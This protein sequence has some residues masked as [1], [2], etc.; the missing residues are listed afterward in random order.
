MTGK[1]YRLLLCHLLLFPIVRGRAQTFQ[2]D[3]STFAN[4]MNSIFQH[5]QR[6]RIPNGILLD[7]AQEFTNL[8]AY[9]GMNLNDSTKTTFTTVS[10]IY[11]TLA[12]GTIT[13][14][15]GSVI[16]PIY[17]DSLAQ[18]QRTAGQITLQ[19]LFYQY[20]SIVPN[21]VTNNLIT[22]TSNQLYDKYVNSV[23]QNPYQTQKVYAMS[24]SVNAYNTRG[25]YALKAK[26]PANLWLTNSGSLVSGM[27]VDFADGLGFRTLTANQIYNLTYSGGG[28]KTWVFKLTLTN[29]TVLQSRTDIQLD[30]ASYLA[31]NSGQKDTHTGLA[32]FNKSYKFQNQYFSPAVDIAMTADNAFYGQKASGIVEIA[33]VNADHKLRKPLIVAEGFDPGDIL[34][35]ETPKGFTNISGFE[36]QISMS[37]SANLLT[38]ISG[39]YDIVYVNW[40]RGA[41]F[42]ER[43]AM[44]LEKSSPM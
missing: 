22:V 36:D 40:N 5:L 34:E 26:M 15:A 35:P 44:L 11:N 29:G 42:I 38:L 41:D 14:P 18:F 16:H 19:G 27:T 9:D 21:A 43:N 12:S 32:K 30:S 8:S 23:W 33:Y 24:P 13:A 3:D 6:P 28:Y 20:A 4:Q 17:Y 2:K 7:F 31:R 39:N 25:T 1:I 10:D 37:S